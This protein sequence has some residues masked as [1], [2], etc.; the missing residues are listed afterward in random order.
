MEGVVVNICYFNYIRNCYFK[1]V[2]LSTIMKKHV[3]IRVGCGDVVL[4][5]K[6]AVLSVGC[7]AIREEDDN[8][9][10]AL[11]QLLV[12]PHTPSHLQAGQHGGFNVGAP[13]RL[14]VQHILDGAILVLLSISLPVVLPCPEILQWTL[15]VLLSPSVLGRTPWSYQGCK[16]R[17]NPHFLAHF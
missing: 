14:Q 3:K 10:D 4:D 7:L 16:I 12:P 17:V 8:W 2:F 5:S 15:S 13:V 6:A 11:G 9:G 1:T